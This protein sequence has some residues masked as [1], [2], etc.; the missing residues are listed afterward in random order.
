MIDEIPIGTVLPYGGSIDYLARYAK[1]W[2]PCDGRSLEILHHPRLFAAL[3]RGWGANP[4]GTTFNLPDLRGVFLRGVSQSSG[5]DPEATSRVVILPGGNSGDN[6]GSLQTC[7]NLQ[8][9]HVVSDNIV[10]DSRYHD[11]VVLTPRLTDRGSPRDWP[12]PRST[13]PSGGS[14]SRPINASVYWI[15]WAPDPEPRTPRDVE[16]LDEHQRLIDAMGAL[17]ATSSPPA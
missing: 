9:S 8:H 14:E 11:N 15:I 12:H 16:E 7:Q 3:G 13:G 17:P 10:S 1:G 2:L 6:V 4:Q 5:R